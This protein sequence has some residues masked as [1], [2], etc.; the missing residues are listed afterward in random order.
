MAENYYQVL[1]VSGN[2]T[3]EEIQKAYRK[4]ARKYH[5]D[6]YADKDDKERNHAKQQFQ[7]VQQAYDILSDPQKRQMY[8][9]FGDQYERAQAGG[10]G[11]GPRGPFEANRESFDPEVLQEFMRQMGGDP[12]AGRGAQGTDGGGGA[13]SRGFGFDLDDIFGAFGGSAGGGNAKTRTPGRSRKGENVDQEITVPFAVAV[14][15]GKHRLNLQRSG[16]PPESI[17]VSIPAGIESGQKIRLRGQGYPSPSGGPAGDM[18]VKVNV[19]PHPKYTRQGLNLIVNLPISIQEAVLG[20]KQ[21][22]HPI[23]LKTPHGKI[24]LTVPAGSSSGK[25]LRLP[26]M[27]IRTKD[28]SGDLI[29]T[30]QIYVP[31]SIAPEEAEMLQRLGT[32]WQPPNRESINW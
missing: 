17:E 1:G 26:G 5:P 25:S 15:G 19:A 32:D 28:R 13:K 7:K 21:L 31:K 12:R 23:D 30:L 24:A 27:G 16:G 2:A 8:D 14:L 18:M 29:V 9:Q 22:N 4:M 11:P 6:L 10:Y 20:T 3:Q